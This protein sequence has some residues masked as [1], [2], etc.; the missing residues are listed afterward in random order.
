VRREL[1]ARVAE[2]AGPQLGPEVHA[3][4]R[5]EHRR[6]RLAQDRLILRDLRA[7]RARGAARHARA[8]PAA[9]Q[10]QARPRRRG[11]D[12]AR[13]RPRRCSCGWHGARPAPGTAVACAVCHLPPPASRGGPGW[14]ASRDRA[15]DRR[16]CALRCIR[17]EV[18]R[19][20]LLGGRRGRAR[21]CR[22]RSCLFGVYS[23]ANGMTHF[24]ASIRLLGQT[25]QDKRRPSRSSSSEKSAIPRQDHPPLPR[26]LAGAAA[27]RLHPLRALRQSFCIPRCALPAPTMCILCG[28]LRS[29]L[30]SQIWMVAAASRG[31]FQ[32]WLS[33]SARK[34]LSSH[35]V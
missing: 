31:R 26:S 10:P 27:P 2:R 34:L 32:R 35:A 13:V 6:A 24:V 20:L 15:C 19:A 30:E 3:R 7:A 11:C 21:T 8:R 33:D 4:V 18:C 17:A 29:L 28:S 25:F 1:V 9:A 5:V 16:R 12:G 14:A 22:P 23:A